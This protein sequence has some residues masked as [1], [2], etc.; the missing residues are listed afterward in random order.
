MRERKPVKLVAQRL[1]HSTVTT[2]YDRYSRLTL[3]DDREAATD[4]AAL[5]VGP[6]NAAP[7]E[8]A[9]SEETLAFAHT[10]AYVEGSRL[11]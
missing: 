4:L 5:I 6:A 9:E 3:E 7:A 8:V 2:T 11:A 10:A 1:G